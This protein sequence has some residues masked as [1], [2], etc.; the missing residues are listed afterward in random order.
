MQPHRSPPSVAA[1]IPTLD[2]EDAI[3]ASCARDPARAS[4]DA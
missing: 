2:E 3:G 4:C 1:I